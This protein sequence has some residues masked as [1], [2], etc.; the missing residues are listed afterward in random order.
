[1][2]DYS[3]K[4]IKKFLK[5]WKDCFEF[6]AYGE[7]TSCEHLKALLGCFLYPVLWSCAYLYVLYLEKRNEKV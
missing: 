5:G 7:G 6:L 4:D 3:R 2:S 1:M